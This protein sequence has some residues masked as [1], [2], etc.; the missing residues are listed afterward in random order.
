M[1]RGQIKRAGAEEKGN[2]NRPPDAPNFLISPFSLPTKGA[3][4]EETVFASSSDWSIALF[5]S[6]VVGQ[7]SNC[8]TL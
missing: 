3:S 4:A 2:G 6:V 7:L 1:G 8:K 5:A